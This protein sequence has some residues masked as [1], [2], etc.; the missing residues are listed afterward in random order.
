MEEHKSFPLM[1]LSTG[2]IYC[3]KIYSEYFNIVYK[4][5]K[6]Y[7]EKNRVYYEDEYLY[8]VEDGDENIYVKMKK[9]LMKIKISPN[10]ITYHFEGD[11]LDLEI[12]EILFLNE[13]IFDQ[14]KE[15]NNDN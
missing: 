8:L 4:C 12:F 11:T 1:E 9:L 14:L 2:K 6:E 10:L 7:S 15:F 5:V 13:N 3:L